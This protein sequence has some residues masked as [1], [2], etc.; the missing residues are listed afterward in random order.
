MDIDF[1]GGPAASSG[2]DWMRVAKNAYKASVQA[3]NLYDKMASGY[4][5]PVTGSAPYP[6][7]P[8]TE[9]KTKPKLRGAPLAR[10]QIGGPQNPIKGGKGGKRNLAKKVK[11]T[12]QL[13][14]KIQKVVKGENP[15][16][17]YKEITGSA[18]QCTLNS[19]TVHHPNQ[20][21][22]NAQPG[23]HFTPT[24]ILDAASALWNTKT[25]SVNKLYNDA[26]NFTFNTAK[27]FVKRQTYTC[28][29]KNLSEHG[30]RITIVVAQPRKAVG[31]NAVTTWAAELAD[32]ATGTFRENPGGALVTTLYNRPGLCTGMR[33]QWKF[34]T[35]DISLEPGQEYTY[36]YEGPGNY[37]MKFPEKLDAAV[38]R[39]LDSKTRNIF[40][41][42]HG[43]LNSTSA[44]EIHRSAN[45]TSGCLLM[46]NV[47]TYSLEMPEQAG[48][49]VAA[50]A[51]PQELNLRRY[52]YRIANFT[53]T[54]AQASVGMDEDN[55]VNVTNP[56]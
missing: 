49:S 31:D 36:R 32:Q 40:F 1:Y 3:K 26:N 21:L 27:I 16:G 13:R 50:A 42:F 19:Q 34:E 39:E 5:R 22:T 15:N 43:D 47:H 24:Q 53:A 8:K 25:T 33:G 48:F 30:Y 44:R 18:A 17:F 20:H 35:K 23:W 54:P 10:R 37:W 29:M 11:V 2:I 41:I 9:H 38:R 14:A 52:A 7:K 46:E 12:K 55:A 56:T 51:N 45:L 28:N 6:K 4:K